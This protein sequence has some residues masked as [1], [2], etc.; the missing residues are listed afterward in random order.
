[1]PS[2]QHQDSLVTSQLPDESVIRGG[3]DKARTQCSKPLLYSGSLDH[4]THEDLTPVIGR[5]IRGLQV[6]DLLENV[7]SDRAIKDL[8]ILGWSTKHLDEILLIF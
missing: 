7:E 5:E 1:M 3:H 8:A 4:F 2:F 6:V